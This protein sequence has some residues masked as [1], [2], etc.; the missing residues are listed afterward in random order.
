MNVEG[1]L[2]KTVTYFK[3]SGHRLTQD[4]DP[5]MEIITK[6]CNKSYFGLGK[7]NKFEID[8][9]TVENKD[10]YNT[11]GHLIVLYTLPRHGHLGKLRN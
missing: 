6:G 1:H 9:K 4:N 11:F 2:F 3:Y 10:V 8:I 5:K 7:I